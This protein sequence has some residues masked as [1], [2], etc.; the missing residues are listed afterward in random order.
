MGFAS[1]KIKF[2]CIF[3]FFILC[4]EH[5][6]LYL[7]PANWTLLGLDYQTICCCL[8]ILLFLSSIVEFGG[9][10]HRSV[11]SWIFVFGMLLIITSAVAGMMT[12]GQS[13]ITGLIVQRSRLGSLLMFFVLYKWYTHGKISLKEMWSTLAVF[14]FVYFVVCLAQF[15]LSGISTFTYSTT[16][17][18]IRYGSVRYWFSGTYLAIMAGY[19]LDRIW[20][21]IGS[22]VWNALLV[23]APFILAFLITKTRMLAI[24]VA[25]A[26][27]FCYLIKP[28]SISGKLSNVV[29]IL[30]V[31]G[32]LAS[33]QLG[34]DI[35]DIFSGVG[36]MTGD[37]LTVRDIGRE[38]YVNVTLQGPLRALFGCG[39]A[40]S[41]NST[42]Y[43]MAYP[44]IYSAEYGYAVTIYPQDNGIFGMFFYY[45]IAG[46]VWWTA[47]LAYL[48]YR[49][50]LLFKKNGSTVFIGFAVFEF[51]S[52][53]TLTPILFSRFILLPL[54][55]VLLIASESD[56]LSQGGECCETRFH[57]VRHGHF[58][59]S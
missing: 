11:Y 29:V 44:A 26:I 53:I 45:G 30:V 21:G 20:Q 17:E 48:F 43:L 22:K 54:I 10:I 6:F 32:F 42:A 15:L 8:E 51:I 18:K 28:R 16:T 33:T 40:S 39:Y 12:Y 41:N 14:S 25:V 5:Q 31:L 36:S 9:Q 50:Y 46:I 27:L 59:L 37:T 56:S 19:G 2:R 13:I 34:S 49:A 24:A 57:A 58:E 35:V 47:S 4:L 38:Y 52:S 7:I 3:I 1:V 55:S 23:I